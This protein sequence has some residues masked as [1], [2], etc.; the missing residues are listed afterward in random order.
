M[1]IQV[2]KSIDRDGLSGDSFIAVTER[3]GVSYVS[4]GQSETEAIGNLIATHAHVLDVKLI[5]RSA[6][7]IQW[8]DETDKYLEEIL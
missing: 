8:A 3:N 2:R 5:R 6:M 7:P 4:S 1:R